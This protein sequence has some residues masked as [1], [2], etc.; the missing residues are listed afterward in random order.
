MAFKDFL[1]ASK[2]VM[3][4]V[5]GLLKVTVSTAGLI[6]VMYNVYKQVSS[7][8]EVTPVSVIETVCGGEVIDSLG[9][10][11]KL[12]D[13]ATGAIIEELLMECQKIKPPE[14]VELDKIAVPVQTEP[15]GVRFPIPIIAKVPVDA[16]VAKEIDTRALNA[17]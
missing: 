11:S 8:K 4:E 10:A 12:A 9:I 17:Q 14:L 6:F 15:H 1:A 5:N 7:I 3:T 2:E 13:P 16:P